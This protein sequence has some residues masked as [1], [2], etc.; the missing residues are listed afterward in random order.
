MIKRRTPAI[1][2]LVLV[3][4]AGSSY[5]YAASN[6]PPL[7]NITSLPPVTAGDPTPGQP[8]LITDP[9]VALPKPSNLA[10]FVKDETALLKLGK[11]LFWDMQLGSDGVQAC[12]SCHFKAG[13][14]NR[15]KN[16]VNPGILHQP[17]QDKFFGNCLEAGALPRPLDPLLDR[18]GEHALPHAPRQCLQHAKCSTQGY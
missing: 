4:A 13:A 9:S 17:A 3:T 12:A 2:S 10:A 5:L 6:P 8:P 1:L 18:P 7:D 16:Q 11:A 14:D 15:S